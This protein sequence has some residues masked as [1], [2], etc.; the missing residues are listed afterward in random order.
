MTSI[1][2]PYNWRPRSYQLP[3]WSFFEN[4]GTRGIAVWHRRSGKDDVCLHRAAVAAFERPATYWHMLP[5]YAQGR[6]AIWAAVNPKTGKRRIDEAF[7]HDIREATNEQ[8]MFIRFRSG[9]TWQVVGSDRYD[10]T[11][12]SPPA[13]ITFSEWALADPA[14]WAYLLPIL[15]ENNGWAAFITTARGRN[16]AKSM[17]D[18]ARKTPGWFGEILTID[19]TARF[20]RAAGERPPITVEQVEAVRA[21]YHSLF[22]IE[23]GDAL[24]EQEFYCSFE[25]AILGAYYGKAMVRADQE[26]RICDFDINDRHPVNTALDIG[27]GDHMRIWWWQ[28]TERG[29]DVIDHAAGD[30]PEAGAKWYVEKIKAKP[31]RYGEHWVPHDAKVVEWGTEKSRIETLIGLGLT[32]RLVP[33]HYVDDGINA[34]RQILPRCRFHQT[35]TAVGLESL[36]QYKKEWDEKNRV[37]KDVPLK[38]WAAHDA[39]T[40]R[41]VAMAYRE[42][43][44]SIPRET[45]KLLVVGPG[46]EVTLDDLW[47]TNRPKRQASERV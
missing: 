10:S 42:L 40:F 24:I 3:F 5:E 30:T 2:L 22:G 29:I 8:E 43:A 21:E 1:T 19:D 7:P 12:G 25:A 28:I 15:L 34:V 31:Y 37:F 36:R 9:S 33:D 35:N 23:D 46:N 26:G 6:K 41:Y 17:L 32:P 18:L 47:E 13:G 39:D 16:H 38:N 14:A 4:G 44:P 20:C 45:Q 11:V 27:K